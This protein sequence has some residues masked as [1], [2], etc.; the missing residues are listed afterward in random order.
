MT[1][2]SALL[3]SRELSSKIY[4]IEKEIS[5]YVDTEQGLH[6]DFLGSIPSS[7]YNGIGVYL[8]SSYLTPRNLTIEFTEIHFEENDGLYTIFYTAQCERVNKLRNYLADKFGCTVPPMRLVVVENASLDVDQVGDLM[9][10]IAET[11]FCP[12][13]LVS[14]MYVF[15]NDNT[16]CVF[17]DYLKFPHAPQSVCESSGSVTDSANSRQP[18]TQNYLS[19]AASK[20]SPS[21][22]DRS[23]RSVSSRAHSLKSATTT[24]STASVGSLMF[25]MFIPKGTPIFGSYFGERCGF[26]DAGLKVFK[27][28]TSEVRQGKIFVSQLS[29][30]VSINHLKNRFVNDKKKGRKVLAVVPGMFLTTQDVGELSRWTFIRITQITKT[31]EGEVATVESY[32]KR[33]RS[34]R[35]VRIASS[36]LNGKI[37]KQG[38]K[39]CVH[40][41]DVDEYYCSASEL[42]SELGFD[43]SSK[44]VTSKIVGTHGFV[45]APA[46]TANVNKMRALVQESSVGIGIMMSTCKVEWTDESLLFYGN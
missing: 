26:T 4:D 10:K 8:Q 34:S 24:K 27:H 42:A 1:F 37:R 44:G 23:K 39:P 46:T 22:S 18:T 20:R 43:S 12:T 31:K 29:G 21:R 16:M 6:I 2:N 30:W 13:V 40:V 35:V 25:P 7:S 9:D 36:L 33:N 32:D 38:P 3:L 41:N 28:D 5:P 45:S 17:E 14:Q 15:V 19:S 11:L